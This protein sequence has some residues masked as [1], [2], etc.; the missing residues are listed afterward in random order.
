LL[1]VPVP[2]SSRIGVLAKDI[3]RF[4]AELIVERG[5]K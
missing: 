1:R 2:I 4:L 3:K 5:R